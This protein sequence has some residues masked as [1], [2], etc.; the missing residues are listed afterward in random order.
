MILSLIGLLY[1]SENKQTIATLN[2]MGHSFFF[3]IGTIY[4]EVFI[5]C[6]TI[7]LLLYV[8]FFGYETYGIL[9]AQ[10]GIEPASPAL[11]DEVLTTGPPGLSHNMTLT[12]IML[13]AGGETDT[14]RTTVKISIYIKF[15]KQAKQNWNLGVL[16]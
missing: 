3:L 16:A 8:L 10:P 13:G 6:V 11:E 15:K 1:S 4:F 9:A 7:L 14:Q 12:N 2:S 5:E